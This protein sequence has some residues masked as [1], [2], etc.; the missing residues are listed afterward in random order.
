MVDRLRASL[1][2]TGSEVT[3]TTKHGTTST[4]DTTNI[5]PPP[6]ALYDPAQ[7]KEI[8]DQAKAIAK[9]DT[10]ARR[11]LLHGESGLFEHLDGGHLSFFSDASASRQL[12]AQ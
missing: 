10:E 5:G 4:M 1:P 2:V 12:R 3:Y 7:A 8:I 9:S 11:D 6:T